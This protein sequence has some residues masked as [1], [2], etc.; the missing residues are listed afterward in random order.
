MP[1]RKEVLIHLNQLLKLIWESEN[2]EVFGVDD[3]PG[4][5][6]RGKNNGLIARG[7][8]VHAAAKPALYFAL[9]VHSFLLSDNST[10]CEITGR[11]SMESGIHIPDDCFFEI[12]PLVTREKLLSYEIERFLI[13]YQNLRYLEEHGELHSES[14]LG[15]T[16]SKNICRYNLLDKGEVRVA[17]R[18]DGRLIIEIT[19]A[20]LL[21]HFKEYFELVDAEELLFDDADLQILLDKMQQKKVN[22]FGVI[23]VSEEGEIFMAQRRDPRLFAPSGY[24]T[25]G[26]HCG[27]PYHPQAVLRK[28]LAKEFGMQ[29]N[30]QA[31]FRLLG[32]KGDVAVYAIEEK[33]FVAP[34]ITESTILAGAYKFKAQ[35]EEFVSGSEEVF[36]FFEMRR[37]QIML[38]NI[39]SLEFYLDHCQKKLGELL[40][41]YKVKILQEFQLMPTLNMRCVGPYFGKIVIYA[42][43]EQG[44]ELDFDK[45]VEMAE[46][47][48]GGDIEIN[49]DEGFIIIS[50]L[51]PQQVIDVLE[52]KK[53]KTDLEEYRETRDIKL[54]QSEA[55]TKIQR[56]TRA[57]L[58]RRHIEKGELKLDIRKTSEANFSDVKQQLMKGDGLSDE[59]NKQKGAHI[60]TKQEEILFDA[61]TELEFVANH[62]NTPFIVKLIEEKG[63]LYSKKRLQQLGYQMP[64]SDS[65]EH[66][67]NGN[68]GAGI[69]LANL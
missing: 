58:G 4:I 35:A 62:I 43:N 17:T 57:Y 61:I 55:A 44:E 60:L 27:N 68:F 3:P 12:D 41:G 63:F 9:V 36:S 37:R 25:C 47:K 67:S 6:F 29:S 42:C 69:F 46:E 10:V 13:S 59:E 22:Y 56:E 24:A 48:F 15:A 21:K 11:D 33:D 14:G 40:E 16:N 20:D 26:G 66:N 38:R 2:C 32:K 50:D 49:E 28:E 65:A 34:K 1:I 52:G 39:D 51:N 19:D 54:S 5:V 64:P 7:D 8:G 45:L 30:A 23:P 18:A 53:D 31:N